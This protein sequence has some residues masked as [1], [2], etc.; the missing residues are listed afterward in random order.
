MF[1]SAKEESLF[2]FSLHHHGLYQSIVGGHVSKAPM[3]YE[4]FHGTRLPSLDVVG[5]NARV[6]PSEGFRL[7]GK[8]LGAIDPAQPA[9]YT[10]LIN[11][12]GAAPP[13]PI[14]NRSMIFYDS[15]VQ[16]VTGPNG[17]AGS[18]TL[19]NSQGAT[20]STVPLPA[21]DVQINGTRVNVSVPASLLPSTS[22]P[23]TRLWIA[24]YFYTFAAGVPVNGATDYAS[25][26]PEYSL[27]PIDSSS[28][29]NV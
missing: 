7:T 28:F 16:V 26:A 1:A 17:T 13:G 15:T 25:F 24:R 4:G 5:A 9:V 14:K 6:I 21:S 3:F 12:G 29:K 18:V 23:H 22:P 20:L 19:M 2:D 8:V 11:R 27:A 10:F